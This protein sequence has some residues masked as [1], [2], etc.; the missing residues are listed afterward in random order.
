MHTGHCY[1]TIY[2][3]MLYLKNVLTIDRTKKNI[4]NT[5]EPARFGN[6]LITQKAKF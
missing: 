5:L 4:K 2:D 6:I 1:N 3:F